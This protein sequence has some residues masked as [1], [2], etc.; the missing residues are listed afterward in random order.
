ML[1]TLLTQQ[2]GQP[3]IVAI[4]TSDILDRGLRRLRQEEENVAA[5]ILKARQKPVRKESKKQI[6]WRNLLLQQINKAETVEQ[7]DAI[8]I[9]TTKLKITAR[10][11]EAI[12]KYREAKR[13][14]IALA[15]KELEVR[16]LEAQAEAERQKADEF[17]KKRNNRIKRLKALMWLAK[18]DL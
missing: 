18:L 17:T 8:E 16:R 9:D 12:E 14:K 10:I 1:T 11:L 13:L 6:E 2:G 3:P 15:Q 4:D 7:L 5:Q